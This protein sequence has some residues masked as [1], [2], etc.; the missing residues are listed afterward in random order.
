MSYSIVRQFKILAMVFVVLWGLQSWAD[1]DAND[2]I[3]L[4]QPNY[5]VGAYYFGAFSAS[6]RSQIQGTARVYGRSDDWWGGI[7]DFYGGEPGVP[8]NARGWPGDYSHLKPS[9]GYYDQRSTET[10]RKHIQQAS[11]A[12]LGFFSFYWYWSKAQ[13]RELLPEALQSFIQANTDGK[14][15]F[16][17]SLYAHPWDPDM[18]IGST[19]ATA[20]AEQIV[21]YF[22][23]PN[24]LRLPDGRPV[25]VMGDH[26][27]ILDL[28]DKKCTKTN[29]HVSAAN[30]FILLLKQVSLSKLGVAP[31]VQIQTGANGW[32]AVG[33]ADG[34]TCL[35]PPILVEGG[36]PYPALD[37]S[38]FAPLSSARKPVSPCMLQ[39]FDERPRQD[40]LITDRSSIRYLVGK[41]GETF[42]HNLDVTR[43][44]ADANFARDKHPASL[45][46]YLYAWNEW[47][48][49]GILE[50][51]VE[52]GA[53]DLNI[54]ADVFHLR[55]GVSRCSNKGAC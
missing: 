17:I 48:E 7:K 46:V 21:A 44:F 16:N 5:L 30:R 42:R 14:M 45:I 43:Q 27:N 18:A 6:A 20:I 40:V 8:K 9:I 35:V 34:V 13:K 49:G 26:R 47:H 52:T 53:E 15:K 12:G 55:R 50:P 22:A 36:T 1:V 37:G 19:N 38:V 25:F 23:D 31:F 28:S 10:L 32:D 41:T 2:A 39:N 24:Y 4:R 33:Q 29:C 54:V 11:D 3:F 51:N